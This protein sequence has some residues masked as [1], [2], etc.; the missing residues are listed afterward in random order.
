MPRQISPA[1]A[2]CFTLNNW[3][4]NEFKFLSSTLIKNKEKYFYIIGKEVGDGG[5]P[6]LQGYI[7]LK[8]KKKKFRPLP[9]FEILRENNKNA[10]HFER[11][12][13][14]RDQNYKYCSKDG[15]FITN[16][17]CR[18]RDEIKSDEA[19]KCFDRIKYL[20]AKINEVMSE[21]GVKDDESYEFAC[22]LCAHWIDK[23][24]EL[25]RIWE[26]QEYDFVIVE[27]EN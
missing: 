13:G 3:T 6:H 19:K 8:A 24:N 20:T 18:T 27:K 23:R 7:A 22:E 15:N 17:D 5:T 21:V 14:N 25:Y 4:E 16:I 9:T 1:N 26:L 2:W 10:M 12:K 11:A